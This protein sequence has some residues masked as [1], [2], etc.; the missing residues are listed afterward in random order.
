[1][2]LCHAGVAS[3]WVLSWLVSVGLAIPE[4][5]ATLTQQIRMLVNIFDGSE[6][7]NLH[8]TSFVENADSRNLAVEEEA[9]QRLAVVILVQNRAIGFSVTHCD[10][11]YRD[12]AATNRTND[13]VSLDFLFSGNDAIWRL[14]NLR[15]IWLWFANFFRRYDFLVILSR[16]KATVCFIL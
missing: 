15:F 16:T 11:G 1:M 7:K 3:F 13:P 10:V 6:I 14:N 12:L 9:S 2:I 4:C 5:P 8:L